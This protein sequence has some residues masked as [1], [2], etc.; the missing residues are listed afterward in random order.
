MNKT[1]EKHTEEE[2]RDTQ[3]VA[4]MIDASFEFNEYRIHI[5]LFLFIMQ[6]LLCMARDSF[7]DDIVVA[8]AWWYQNTLA[9]AVSVLWSIGLLIEISWEKVVLLVILLV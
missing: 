2:F 8:I 1:A 3:V 4:W 6:P 5:A 9:I 7:R